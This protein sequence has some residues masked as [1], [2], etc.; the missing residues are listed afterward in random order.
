M[1]SAGTCW[2]W[3]AAT[4]PQGYGV[5]GVWDPEARRARVQR[6]WVWAF[7]LL[8]GSRP[9]GR[10]PRFTCRDHTCINPRHIVFRARSRTAARPHSLPS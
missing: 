9:E 8:Y 10:N 4:D 3:L 7:I 5:F 2:H 1:P 6:A